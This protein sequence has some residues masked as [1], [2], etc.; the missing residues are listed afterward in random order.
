MPSLQMVFVEFRPR[1]SR[2]GSAGSRFL[3]RLPAAQRFLL[4]TANSC[5]AGLQRHRVSVGQPVQLVG[6]VGQPGAGRLG[7]HERRRRVQLLSVASGRS[8][9]RR[10]A[11]ILLFTDRTFPNQARLRSISA[12]RRKVCRRR[13]RSRASARSRRQCASKVRFFVLIDRSMRGLK[14]DLLRRRSVATVADVSPAL[15]DRH[16][17]GTGSSATTLSRALG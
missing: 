14:Q 16:A 9:C 7:L 10:V 4:Q 2:A 3:K 8:A 13:C 15:V 1:H 12:T 5:C 6:A 11:S 17:A